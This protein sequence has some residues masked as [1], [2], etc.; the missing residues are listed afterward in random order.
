MFGGDLQNEASFPIAF[1]WVK[2]ELT[3]SEAFHRLA[4]TEGQK[5]IARRLKAVQKEKNEERR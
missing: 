2:P 1:R 3:D 5:E 4:L